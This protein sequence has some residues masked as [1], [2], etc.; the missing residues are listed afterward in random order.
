M[1]QTLGTIEKNELKLFNRRIE[2]INNNK[3]KEAAKEKK[4]ET[5][6]VGTNTS[7][8]LLLEGVREISTD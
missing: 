5:G 4:F 8:T 2:S 3:K 6:F 7:E 1:N